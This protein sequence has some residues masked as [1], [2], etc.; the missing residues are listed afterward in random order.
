MEKDS[1]SGAFNPL[2]VR[3]GSVEKVKQNAEAIDAVISNYVYAA[4]QLTDNLPSTC[5]NGIIKNI[6]TE[7]LD[8]TAQK[9]LFKTNGKV[10]KTND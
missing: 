7:G 6:I 9:V 2:T 8:I 10:K 5:Y 3:F 1:K 4:S